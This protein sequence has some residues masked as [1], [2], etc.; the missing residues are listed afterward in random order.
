[1]SQ[2]AYPPPPQGQYPPPP[3]GQYPPPPQGYPSQQ[4]YAP[5]PGQPQTT[6]IAQPVAVVPC[7]TMRDIPVRVTCPSCRADVMTSTVFETGTMTWLLAG[8]LCILGCWPCCL[9]P[10]CVEGCKDVIH[11]CPNC[12]TQVGVYRRM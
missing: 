6:V 8:I 12:Q 4:G 10:F 3:Q 9:I 11:T 1:M 7:M 5:P 2:P